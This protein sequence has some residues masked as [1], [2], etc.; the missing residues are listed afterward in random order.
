M[1]ESAD[2]GAAPRTGVVEGTLTTGTARLRSTKRCEEM[3]GESESC[4]PAYCR[5]LFRDSPASQRIARPPEPTPTYG[6][7]STTSSARFE[8]PQSPPFAPLVRLRLGLYNN[9]GLCRVRLFCVS[10][11]LEVIDVVLAVGLYSFPIRFQFYR[12]REFACHFSSSVF[13]A[14]CSCTLSC[15]QVAGPAY[16]GS[17]RGM[18]APSAASDA[19]RVCVSV[20]VRMKRALT[21]TH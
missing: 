16:I 19:A 12:E 11:K 5:P 4:T 2:T 7:R 3:Y 8:I 6:S 13:K 18:F 15:E 21:R 20:N 14:S 17:F 10:V 1:R 9:C